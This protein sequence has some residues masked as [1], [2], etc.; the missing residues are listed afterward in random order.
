MNRR[1]IMAG[2]APKLPIYESKFM[3]L[4][5]ADF[6]RPTNATLIYRE[7]EYSFNAEPRPWNTDT[8]LFAP[9]CGRC[10]NRD[11]FSRFGSTHVSYPPQAFRSRRNGRSTEHRALSAQRSV[12][13]AF[14][15]RPRPPCSARIITTSPAATRAPRCSCCASRSFTPRMSLRHG[16]R[17][18]HRSPRLLSR[19]HHQRLARS[20]EGTREKPSSMCL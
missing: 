14:L 12:P 9:G 15:L 6:D 20:L 1:I 17:S 4:I 18:R 8:S 2:P 11:N 3:R 13:A 16:V 10:L 7:P 19:F 5:A